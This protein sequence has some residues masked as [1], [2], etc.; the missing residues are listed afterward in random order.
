MTAGLTM[1]SCHPVI[2]SSLHPVILSLYLLPFSPRFPHSF[3]LSICSGLHPFQLGKIAKIGYNRGTCKISYPLPPR[4]K[5]S[6]K[7]GLQS[8]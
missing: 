6:P 7:F 3:L 2:L 8:A 5:L 4:Q 1:S